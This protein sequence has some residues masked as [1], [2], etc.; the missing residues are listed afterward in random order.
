VDGWYIYI[1]EFAPRPHNSGHVTR[2]ACTASQFDILAR[3]LMG[4]PICE[5]KILATGTYCMGNLLGDVWLSQSAGRD[6]ANAGVGTDLDLR[7]WKDH[8]SIID[9]VLYGK[10]EARSGRKMGHFVAYGDTADDAVQSAR[11]FRQQ[12]SQPSSRQEV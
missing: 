6:A 8:P 5:P 2:N 4:V 9:V 11:A 3:I 7:A 1:N 12:L 10:H